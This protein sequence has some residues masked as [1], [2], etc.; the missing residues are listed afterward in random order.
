MISESSVVSALV[1]YSVMLLVIWVLRRM[2][3]FLRVGGGAI[4]LLGLVLAALRVVVP[5]E[6]PA[7]YV[8]RSDT[9]LAVPQKFCLEHP[10]ITL[11]LAVV[12]GIGAVFFVGRD[13]VELI[14]AYRTCR[15][16]HILEDERVRRIVKECRVSIPVQVTS[17]VE[18]PFVAGFANPVIYL[19]SK[20]DVTDREI[21]LILAHETQH[22]RSHDVYIKLAFGLIRAVLWWNPIVQLCRGE[23]DV[24][25]ELRCDRK[26]TEH[27]SR[28][29]KS[30]YLN[31]LAKVARRVV[32]KKR[33]A[34]ALNESAA[35][36][37]NT[38]IKQRFAIISAR[39]GNLPRHLYTVAKCVLPVLFLA[40]YFVILVPITQPVGDKFEERAGVSY[41]E[42]YFGPEII[43]ER[44]NA[45]ILKGSDG[46]YQLCINYRFVRYL[47]EDEIDSE[48]YEGLHVFGED[49]Q[50]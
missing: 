44:D 42:D 41:H 18:V 24:L 27:M 50:R 6:V 37:G 34:L 13:L 15:E 9:V 16:Y 3:S 10:D 22:V 4:L 43:N 40:S 1:L 21:E 2:T 20:L 26:V 35:V 47:S 12:W 45:F 31:M 19:P 36:D 11:R 14:Q 39:V 33:P 49:R 8:I 32:D 17:D 7:A 23:I 48:E 46:R 38:L 30:E 28:G 5:L 29:E 25:L